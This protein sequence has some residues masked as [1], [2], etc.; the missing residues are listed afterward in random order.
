MK[1]KGYKY[2]P[3]TEDLLSMFGI[4]Y[5]L[6]APTK[7]TTPN[8]GNISVKDNSGIVNPTND[9]VVTKP[10]ENT[11]VNIFTTPDGKQWK[12]DE[13]GQLVPVIVKEEGSIPAEQPEENFEELV[14][15]IPT[16]FNPDRTAKISGVRIG[17]FRVGD[18]VGNIFDENGNLITDN[19]IGPEALFTPTDETNPHYIMYKLPNGEYMLLSQNGIGHRITPEFADQLS[20]GKVAYK[21]I[22]KN[23]QP[24]VYKANTK[25]EE[26]GKID[27]KKVDSLVAKNSNK[28]A[29]GEN[30]LDLK[31]LPDV[32]G[33]YNYNIPSALKFVSPLISTGRFIETSI[34]QRKDR[35]LAKKM[36]N[37][38]RFNDLAV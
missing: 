12:L 24:L 33:G 3:E 17:G 6:T 36:L 5:G 30:G 27:F 37:E 4:T 20:N 35:D 19:S 21:D 1:G 34:A 7:S 14:V 31:D 32:G 23:L 16:F 25:K 38:G 13:N 11:N 2:D 26:G 9:S 15:R 29:K 10:G 22:T 18:G 8:T 28:I